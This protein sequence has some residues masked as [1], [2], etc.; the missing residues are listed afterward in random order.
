MYRT[1]WAFAVI[2]GKKTWVGYH[3]PHS[4]GLPIVKEAWTTCALLEGKIG[5]N[6]TKEQIITSNFLYAKNYHPLDDLSVMLRK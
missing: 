5:E 6:A 2:G 3:T 4:L 1:T